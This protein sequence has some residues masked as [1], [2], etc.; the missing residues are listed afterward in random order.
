MTVVICQMIDP[1]SIMIINGHG[2]L[3]KLDE[4]WIQAWKH[5]FGQ[6]FTFL[7]ISK[8]IRKL[9]VL[10]LPSFMSGKSE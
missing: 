1:V 9:S 4:V 10:L 5:T 7:Y 2:W 3:R 8:F 6:I